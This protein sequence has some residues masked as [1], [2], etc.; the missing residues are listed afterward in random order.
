MKK[1]IIIF[2]LIVLWIFTMT[3]MAATYKRTQ[4]ADYDVKLEHMMMSHTYNYCP[5]CGEK[6]ESEDKE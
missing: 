6:L 3:A 2:L 5:I 4:I 1:N